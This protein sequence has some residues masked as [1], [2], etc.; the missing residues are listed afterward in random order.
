MHIVRTDAVL[1]GSVCEPRRRLY[2]FRSM[3]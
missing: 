3:L 1:T 2:T